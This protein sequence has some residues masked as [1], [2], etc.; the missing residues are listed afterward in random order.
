MNDIFHPGTAFPFAGGCY[1]FL[2]SAGFVA[3]LF[4]LVL[5]ALALL[6]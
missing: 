6:M 4:G 5:L 2:A 3:P 1:Y